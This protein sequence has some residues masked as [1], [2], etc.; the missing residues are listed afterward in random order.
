MGNKV[1]NVTFDGTTH[2]IVRYEGGGSK[3]VLAGHNAKLVQ[4]NDDGVSYIDGNGHPYYY[5]LNTHGITR[6]D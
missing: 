6:C 3:A 1:V 2:F 5:N 4:Y